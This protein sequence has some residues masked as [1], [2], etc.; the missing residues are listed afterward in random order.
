MK[1][2]LFSFLILTF[3][4]SFAIGQTIE[5]DE[6][7][8]QSD[9]IAFTV[10]TLSSATGDTLWIKVHKSKKGVPQRFSMNSFVEQVS[11]TSEIWVN[12]YESNTLDY[13]SMVQIGTEDTLKAGQ[14][15]HKFVDADGFDSR[16]LIVIYIAKTATQSTRVVN[17]TLRGKLSE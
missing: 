11:G 7:A 4:V 5:T 2:K 10:D 9:P 14:L 15:S 8:Y 12:F 17:N 13:A 3:L 1:K 16:Y 6:I